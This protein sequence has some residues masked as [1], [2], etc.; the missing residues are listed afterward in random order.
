[1]TITTYHLRTPR[2]FLRNWRECDLQPFIEMNAD[3]D[4]MRYFP[5]LLTAAQVESGLSRIRAGLAER[6]WGLWAVE[7]PGVTDFAGFIGLSKPAFNAHFTPCVEIGWRLA[8]AFHGQGYATEGARAALA[9]GFDTLGLDEI[10][11]FTVPDN[12]PSR[13][14]MEKL[15]MS[16]H[17]D[18]DFEHPNLDVGHPLRKH[19]LYRIRRSNVSEASAI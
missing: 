8:R 18:D 5:S 19:V 16:H 7:I 2:L 15:G 3:P 4:V 11:S 13:R 12:A 9:F 10:V 17:A 6:G 1:M 14:V